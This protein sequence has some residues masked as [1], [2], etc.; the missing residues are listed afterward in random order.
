MR[1]LIFLLIGLSVAFSSNAADKQQSNAPY[2]YQFV[3]SEIPIVVDEKIIE[4]PQD[5]SKIFRFNKSKERKKYSHVR[6]ELSENFSKYNC[7]LVLKTDDSLTKNY[8]QPN[9]PGAILKELTYSNVSKK[10]FEYYFTKLLNLD[11]DKWYRTKVGKELL[12][13]TRVNYD[14]PE[15]SR[16]NIEL[17]LGKQLVFLN[18]KYQTAGVFSVRK[19]AELP[20]TN[21]VVDNNKIKYD[22]DLSKLK[23]NK[24]FSPIKINE[25]YIYVKDDGEVNFTP[26]ITVSPSNNDVE[27]IVQRV[28]DDRIL[29]DLSHLDKSS[30]ESNARIEVKGGDRCSSNIR[31]V[32]FVNYIFANFPDVLYNSRPYVIGY[33][34]LQLGR[35]EIFGSVN[36]IYV[37]KRKILT[38]GVTLKFKVSSENSILS[39]TPINDIG[40]KIN[41]NCKL[42]FHLDNDIPKSIYSIDNLNFYDKT[43]KIIL[44]NDECHDEYYI[45]TIT[46]PFKQKINVVNALD[47]DI[48]FPQIR[49]IKLED[50]TNPETLRYLI[51]KSKDLHSKY[52]IVNDLLRSEQTVKS[53]Q[54]ISERSEIIS[55]VGDSIPKVDEN[56]IVF[57]LEKLLPYGFMLKEVNVTFDKHGDAS[58]YLRTLQLSNVEGYADSEIIVNQN[59]SKRQDINL[60]IKPPAEWNNYVVGYLNFNNQNSIACLNIIFPKLFNLVP[61]K[62]TEKIC[63]SN[64]GALIDF[65][66]LNFYLITFALLVVTILATRKKSLIINPHAL[67]QSKL[68]SLFSLLLVFIALIYSIGQPYIGIALLKYVHISLGAPFACLLI[69]QS[70]NTDCRRILSENR[71]YII[72][73]SVALFIIS[74]VLKEITEIISY[75]NLIFF[76][77]TAFLLCLNTVLFR[78]TVFDIFRFFGSRILLII[79]TIL[80][81]YKIVDFFSYNQSIR[82]DVLLL[83]VSLS[84]MY[85]L[86]NSYEFIK[87]THLTFLHHLKIIAKFQ[88]YKFFIFSTLILLI[89]AAIFSQLLIARYLASILFFGLLFSTFKR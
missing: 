32:Y 66:T 86:Y 80:L 1:L 18:V 74:I 49:S 36:Q 67:C 60:H 81:S 85:M 25:L 29:I 35:Y 76:Y 69:L 54:F 30:G 43:H 79:L 6:F 10:D 5:N 55:V 70:L 27:S 41:R 42:Q 75:R 56:S 52:L 64:T 2:L 19:N 33:K 89:I 11:N 9:Y 20:S 88:F 44:S 50:S 48:N 82:S 16:L 39:L 13:Q 4:K 58:A 83:I 59:T 31:N 65:N 51:D 45:V 40:S 78:I 57:D 61:S 46:E 26:G 63:N 8:T 84:Y 71:L 34:D 15:E 3:T 22:I 21:F 23:Q 73:F 24:K 7:S 37:F 47:R 12:F 72:G 28:V 87:H 38:N 77:V 17:P 68:C 14:L 62:N 53:V